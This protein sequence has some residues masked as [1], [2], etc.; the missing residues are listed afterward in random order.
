MCSWFSSAD[1][2][3]KTPPEVSKAEGISFAVKNKFIE[4][5]EQKAIH[6]HVGQLKI[7]ESIWFKTDGAW[8]NIDLL[9]YLLGITG[10]AVVY[11]STWAISEISI[12]K[13]LKWKSDGLITDLFAVIDAGLRNRKPAIYQQA[14][15]AFPNLKIAHCHAKATVIQNDKYDIAFIGSAN[16]TRNPRIE[17]GTITWNK[18]VAEGNKK[19]IEN[20]INRGNA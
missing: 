17:V 18:E 14:V 9:E 5:T 2:K 13:F 20:E 10:P 19:W 16:Y 8:S 4:A 15:M 7:N 3:S 1:L 6:A 12:S 11:F